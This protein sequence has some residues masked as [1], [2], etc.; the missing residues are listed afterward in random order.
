MTIAVVRLG[1]RESNQKNN[2]AATLTCINYI[3]TLKLLFVI[4][5]RKSCGCDTLLAFINPR[6]FVLMNMPLHS[7]TNRMGSSSIWALLLTHCLLGNFLEFFV[8]LT[9]S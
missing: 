1:H 8:R 5:I 9:M 7:D 4:N 6:L 2:M 3:N